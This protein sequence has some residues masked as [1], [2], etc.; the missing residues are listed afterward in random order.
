MSV[1]VV[2]HPESPT[3]ANL[4]ITKHD[5]AF[6]LKKKKKLK[7]NFFKSDRVVLTEPEANRKLHE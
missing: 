5:Q 1:C 3:Q 7:G 4:E 2:S 6:S